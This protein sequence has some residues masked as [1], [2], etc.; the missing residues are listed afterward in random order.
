MLSKFLIVLKALTRLLEVVLA[1]LKLEN[2]F[3]VF[4]ITAI[5]VTILAISYLTNNSNFP[6]NLEEKISI[7]S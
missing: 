7:N 5:L 2:G 6:P 3:K 1:I 4:V